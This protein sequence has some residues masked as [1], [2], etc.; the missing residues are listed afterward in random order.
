MFQT[1]PRRF[2]SGALKNFNIFGT[3]GFAIGTAKSRGVMNELLFCKKN[4][5]TVTFLQFGENDHCFFRDTDSGFYLSFR[6]ASGAVKLYDKPE[7]FDL[8]YVDGDWASIK[9]HSAK[10]Y[11]WLEKEEPYITGYGEKDHHWRMKEV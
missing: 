10:Q 7:Y 9:S 1:I 2:F 8:S 3:N 11:M 6:D 4:L 5:N